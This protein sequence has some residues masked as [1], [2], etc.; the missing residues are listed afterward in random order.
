MAL[1]PAVRA[2]VAK[3][4]ALPD[5]G[6]ITTRIEV[7][8]TEDI[9]KMQKTYLVGPAQQ[10]PTSASA[11]HIVPVSLRR[12]S[13]LDIGSD[14]E[15]ESLRASARKKKAPPGDDSLVD[16]DFKRSQQDEWLVERT[17]QGVP[18]HAP[19]VRASLFT[20]AAETLLEETQQDFA[21][22]TEQTDEFVTAQE[23]VIEEEADEFAY[24]S[25]SD[26]A[27]PPPIERSGKVYVDKFGEHLADQQIFRK[28]GTQFPE[29]AEEDQ[30]AHT[31]GKREPHDPAFY[32]LE[33]R[34]QS[35]HEQAEFQ[36]K[37][38]VL[39]SEE[40]MES[41]AMFSPVRKTFAES[42]TLLQCELSKNAAVSKTDVVVKDDRT[43][44]AIKWQGAQVSEVEATTTK[45]ELIKHEQ[46]GSFNVTV[47]EP[48][49]APPQTFSSRE[50]GGEKWE[51]HISL[52]KQQPEGSINV[53]IRE[54][55]Q[56]TPAQHKTIESSQEDVILFKQYAQNV[57][58]G[59]AETLLRNKTK[60][61][62]VSL[63]SCES[64]EAN[65]TTMIYLQHE[66]KQSGEALGTLVLP[67]RSSALPLNTD[68]ATEETIRKDLD[69][70]SGAREF[71]D[72]SVAATLSAKN[73]ASVS[74][75]A[76]ET[77]DSQVA[78]MI[79][80]QNAAPL[81]KIAQEAVATISERQL[82]TASFSGMHATEIEGSSMFRFENDAVRKAS[83]EQ[84]FV[85]ARATT[86]TTLSTAASAEAAIQKN[87]DLSV[88]E[89]LTKGAAQRTLIAANTASPLLFSA[90][91]SGDSSIASMIYLQNTARST[92]EDVAHKVNDARSSLGHQL[93][94]KAAGDETESADISLRGAA[95]LTSNQESASTNI[96]TA[97]HGDNQSLTTAASREEDKTLSMALSRGSK[98]ATASSKLT[99][100]N[101]FAPQSLTMVEAGSETESCAIILH[102]IHANAKEGATTTLPEAITGRVRVMAVGSQETAVEL[103]VPLVGHE[104]SESDA[105]VSVSLADANRPA[106]HP[107]LTTQVPNETSRSKSMV[108]QNFKTLLP[109]HGAA[110]ITIPCANW[111]EPVEFTLPAAGESAA[112]CIAQITRSLKEE[113]HADV[114]RDTPHAPCAT[115]FDVEPCWQ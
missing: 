90:S 94:T 53:T 99:A 37:R 115:Y 20:S 18:Q 54:A 108:I 92:A 111:A 15:S 79:V 81:S 40:S 95:A 7:E 75:S 91:E 93:S 58:E 43:G 29:E 13:S 64:S 86:P 19:T 80:L 14:T 1:S 85:Q 41:D 45:V 65:A 77:A 102:N 60:G 68:A 32:E 71:D 39:P 34:R 82:S 47:A 100:G 104:L 83:V 11:M 35:Y 26:T 109:V 27:T 17:V 25:A 110:S 50:V 112:I 57:P 33:Q 70:T 22:I 46:D 42:D 30:L 72:L 63:T 4:E 28:P 106:V 69:I 103:D 51:A 31:T 96:V 97:L 84:I 73:A 9:T 87:V 61:E 21:R 62:A 6:P 113:A 52:S 89:S 10:I 49:R 44:P 2:I 107:E 24:E 8:I 59:H 78:C 114:V 55:N 16:V 3:E 36:R 38:A 67:M 12:S 76:D 48:Q 74:F 56:G 88:D 5:E 23:T 101:T 105:R 98:S 66:G